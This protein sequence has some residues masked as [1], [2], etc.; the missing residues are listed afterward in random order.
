MTER[1]GV[2][3]STAVQIME[4]A[5]GGEWRRIDATRARKAERQGHKNNDEVDVHASVQRNQRRHA[6]NKKRQNTRWM[7]I[8]PSLCVGAWQ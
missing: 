5:N 8:G 3:A 2:G 4:R 6:S 7:A 1:E